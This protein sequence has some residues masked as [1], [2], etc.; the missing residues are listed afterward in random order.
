[1]DTSNV[2][3]SVTFEERISRLFIFRFLWIYIEIWVMFV[4]AI[5]FNIA[6]VLQF[7]FMF[8]M[9][10]RSKTLWDAQMRYMRNMIKWQSYIMAVSNGR[11]KFIED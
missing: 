6:N 9:G 10:K 1:M 5:W 3:Y 4:W 8:I 2:T 11:P 7:L